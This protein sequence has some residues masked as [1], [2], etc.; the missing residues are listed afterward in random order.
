MYEFTGN[1]SKKDTIKGRKRYELT[2][3]RNKR[4]EDTE[5]G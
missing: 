4:D 2:L 1:T 3:R 5:T